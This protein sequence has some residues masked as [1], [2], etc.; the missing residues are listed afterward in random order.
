MA[1]DYK[2][3]VT[4]DTSAFVA[5]TNRMARA[6]EQAEAKMAKAGTDRAAAAER[7]D[8]K[9]V[10]AKARTAA[11]LSAI[12]DRH[13]MR[14]MR[15]RNRYEAMKIREI[16]RG[17]QHA[18]RIMDME[19]KAAERLAQSKIRSAQ[20]AA[21]AAKRIADREAAESA[22][23]AKENSR[24]GYQG[25]AQ[26][27]A[28]AVAFVGAHQGR[29]AASEKDAVAKLDANR[30]AVRPVAALMNV[31][32]DAA[33]N[34]MTALRKGAG[35][36][37]DAANTFTETYLG[38]AGAGLDKG[39]RTQGREG[40]T[41]DVSDRFMK[42]ALTRNAR[43]GGDAATSA[44][45]AGILSMYVPIKSPEQGLKELADI[46]YVL[47]PGRGEDP[48]LTRQLLKSMGSLTGEGMPLADPKS[49]GAFL[50]ALSLTAGPTE[51][52]TRLEQ[53]NRAIL[54][55]LAD[56]ARAPY[57]QSKG[58][59]TGQGFGEW[60]TAL[61]PD[62]E[63]AQLKGEGH[64]FLASKGYQS[65]EERTA[66][67][68]MV[69][70]RETAESVLKRRALEAPTGAQEMAENEAYRRSP[71]GRKAVAGAE[72]D[73]FD[74]GRARHVQ[75]HYARV[76]EA[77]NDPATRAADRSL[78]TQGLDMVRGL[79]RGSLGFEAGR[80]IR[81][82]EM[83]VERAKSRALKAGASWG[84]ITSAEMAAGRHDNP[85]AAL[86]A[87]LDKLADRLEA[88]TAA[89]EANTG[90][91]AGGGPKGGALPPAL[92]NPPANQGRM[93]P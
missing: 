84:E 54:G 10:A 86:G 3:K 27:A 36:T 42:E 28:A 68:E 22:Q 15:T 13:L 78:I 90:G 1:K 38:S 52:G 65:V 39:L 29:L 43:R 7:Q 24:Q 6:M 62:I 82:E 14:D 47:A 16:E 40:I 17:Y 44:D 45:L 79:T 48:V 33:L 35:V 80:E 88:N 74:F 70:V 87:R 41:Q 67:L 37:A 20:R 46:A 31:G 85:L 30:T 58:I 19:A 64:T 34:R 76:A 77:A 91:P 50:G 57:L 9:A 5:G 11:Q 2:I 49:A 25:A 21:E 12:E 83:A 81:L 60:F 59:K 66:I 26:A 32:A 4:L 69:K 72:T 93:V 71:E 63:A 51:S 61:A 56:P 53:A 55:G 92:R 75:S 73:S 18:N 8:A 89:T 23:R